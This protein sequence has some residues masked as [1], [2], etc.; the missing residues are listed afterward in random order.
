MSYQSVLIRSLS[1]LLLSS[2]NDVRSGAQSA[3]YN[4]SSTVI[5][6]PASPVGENEFAHLEPLVTASAQDIEAMASRRDE[7]RLR[8]AS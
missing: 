3:Q 2:D 8:Y 1:S 7:G 6:E 4:S 5:S